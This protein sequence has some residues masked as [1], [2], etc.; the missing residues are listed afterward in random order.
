MIISKLFSLPCSLLVGLLAF[1]GT[2]FAGKEPPSRPSSSAVEKEYNLL[3]RLPVRHKTYYSYREQFLHFKST[4]QVERRETGSGYYTQEVVRL[5]PD[6]APV[7][8]VVR[9][10]TQLRAESAEQKSAE[11]INLDFGEGFTYEV[12]FGEN[13]DYLPIDTSHLPNTLPGFMMFENIIHSH[14]FA[15]LA[16]KTHG[17]LDQLRRIGDTVTIP[18][19]GKGGVVEFPGLLSITLVRGKSTMTFLGLSKYG[20]E[21]A[22]L[23]SW[24]VPLQFPNISGGEGTGRATGLI[25]ISLRDGEVLRGYLRQTTIHTLKG[26]N[27]AVTPANVDLEGWLEKIPQAD[28]STSAQ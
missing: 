5:R 25:W 15:I 19:S 17:A 27:G 2:G 12:C 10:H 8:R 16:T 4:G 9:N 24:D 28:Y 6:G 13:Y 23:L 3:S 14:Q 7:S 1:S 21:P 11:P 20:A 22:A 26:P 18:D